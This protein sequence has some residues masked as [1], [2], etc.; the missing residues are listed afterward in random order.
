MRRKIPISK[1]GDSNDKGFSKDNT[2][3]I[4][5]KVSIININQ[6]TPYKNN[7]KEHTPEQIEKLKGSIQRN[8]YIQPIVIDADNSIVIGHARYEALRALNGDNQVIEVVRVDYLSESEIKALRILDNKINQ[9]PWIEDIL[10][11][12]IV[13]LNKVFSDEEMKDLVGLQSFEINN[14][15][16][17]DDL[18]YEKEWEGMPE[19][20]QKDKTAFRSIV[21]HFKDQEKLDMFAKKMKQT[22]TDKTKYLWYP[23]I[24]IETLADKEYS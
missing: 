2:I 15:I 12:E 5:D 10:N 3:T 24:E 22:I 11:K 1:T 19:F 8:S 6:I 16:N 21:V 4:T 18:D 13:E 9:S 14:A 17:E 23:N 7:A 20:S